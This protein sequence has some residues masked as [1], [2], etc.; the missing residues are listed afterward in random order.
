M[1]MIYLGIANELNVAN[2]VAVASSHNLFE[3]L[4]LLV[5]VMTSFTN[6]HT[7]DSK[8]VDREKKGEH[9]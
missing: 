4:L 5:I 9:F 2:V 8:N 7:I 3:W 1:L 6:K